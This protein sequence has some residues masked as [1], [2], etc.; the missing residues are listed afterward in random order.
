MTER[1]QK[2]TNYLNNA[3]M[4][5][6]LIKSKKQGKMTN[7]LANMVKML[8]ARYAQHPWFINYTY[9]E[10]MQ[11]FALLTVA[12]FWDRFDETRFTN[13]FAYFTQTIKRAFYQY[14]IQEKKHRT[15]RD[16]LLVERGENPSFNFVDEY[17]AD[18]YHFEKMDNFEKEEF[19]SFDKEL[20][21]I[22]EELVKQEQIVDSVLEKEAQSESESECPELTAKDEVDE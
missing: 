10:D 20:G 9:N 1:K 6:E 21:K 4:L 13:V 16:L 8:C 14:N 22:D 5:A 7:E 19:K 17:D 11:A 2:K 15:I 12:R 18:N 3:D